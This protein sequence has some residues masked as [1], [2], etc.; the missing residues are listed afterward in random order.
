M[1]PV[2]RLATRIF[3][4]N[5]AEI[6]FQCRVYDHLAAGQS[7]V[8]QAPTGAGKTLAALAPFA[9]GVWG[10]D[11]GP[12]ARKLIYSLPLRVLA[13]ALRAQYDRDFT[14]EG[15]CFTNQYGGAAEDAFLDGGDAYWK[16][17]DGNVAPSTRHAIFTT[18]DQTLSGFIGVPV[19]LPY[20]LANVMYGSV[21]SG[22][23]VFD[24]F[25]LLEPQR[26]LLTSLA[27]LRRSPWP[28]LVMT[29][30]MSTTLRH[31]LCA[32]LDAE[33]V[34]VDK[35]DVPFIRSQHR[36]VKRLYTHNSPLDGKTLAGEL[37]DRTLVICNTVKRAQTVFGEL[38]E[39][40]EER[41]DERPCALLHS[42]FL[43]RHRTEKERKVTGDEEGGMEGW[44]AKGATGKAVLVATQVVEAGL[45]ISAQALHT[46]VAPIDSLLQ[47]V[48]RT[49]RFAGEHESDVHVYRLEDMG[50]TNPY[51]KDAVACTWEHLREQAKSPGTLTYDDLQGLIDTVLTKS[52]EAIVSS[53]KTQR[54]PRAERIEEVR[55]NVDW[56]GAQELVRHID[57]VEVVVAEPQDVMRAGRS[58]YAY[59]A[60][61]VS[62]STFR[63]G[64]LAEGGTAQAVASHTDEAGQGT[65]RGERYYELVPIH[66]EENEWPSS[67]FILSPQQARYT[68]DLGLVLGEQ[69]EM[70]F[71]FT[72][73]APS[74]VKREYIKESYELHV[75]RVLAQ[76]AIRQAPLDA[77]RRLST[78][79]AHEAIETRDPERLVELV[80]WAHD[81]AK[82]TEGWQHACGNEDPPL[83]HGGRIEGR[84]PPPHAAESAFIAKDLLAFLLHGNED[85]NAYTA[86]LQAIRQHH[87]PQTTR[88]GTF[89]VSPSRQ[90]YAHGI[91]GSL[92]PSY[93][94]ALHQL[95]S[96]LN[97][98]NGEADDDPG[99]LDLDAR[100]WPVYAL[101]VYML[102]R[103]D[104]LAT[105]LASRPME[106]G[107]EDDPEPPAVRI[108]NQFL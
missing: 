9:D 98:T 61:S 45:D 3:G 72:D 5:A 57:N 4:S 107:D 20:R 67:R 34:V 64:F 75:R 87:S 53:C 38:K 56:S 23:L 30:T 65:E 16:P 35:H 70:V 19:S 36:T 63:Y 66:S 28:V 92:V 7:V 62:A 77:L 108:Q 105:S 93:T 10:V 2:H 11:T 86:A 76:R 60:V 55:R 59:E 81:L 12:A 39:G 6:P 94:P 32:M 1:H 22:A 79:A 83:A 49:A 96:H 52:H 48:G 104:Q 13:G 51:D 73:D 40:L 43:P 21:L 100:A 54:R 89:R 69:G 99:W 29:A 84:R 27:L 91:T 101:L 24:E 50:K 80:I 82:L 106:P 31:E 74:W 26:S 41:G 88:L 17:A 18:I 15:V 25:H 44:F 58:P 102:R 37:A 95:W 14:G 68:E 46:E 8:L 47:R 33:P 71:D 97:W 42:R 90:Q 85:R 103:S 78:S